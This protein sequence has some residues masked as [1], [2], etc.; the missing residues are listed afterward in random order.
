MY[1]AVIFDFDYT[2]GDTTDG[3][4]QSVNYALEELGYSSRDV[5]EIKRT[6]GMSL[7]ETFAALT[8]CEDAEKSESFVKLFR[9]KADEVMTDS[10]ELYDCVPEILRELHNT[11]RIGIVTTKFHYRIEAIL[12]KFSAAELVDVIVGAEDVKAEKP[13]PEGLLSAIS[14]LDVQKSEALYVGDSTVDAQTAQ[15]AE[16]DFAAV[17]TGTTTDFSQYHSVFVGESISD[18]F[19]FVTKR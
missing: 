11:R 12:R 9:E 5:S 8:D 7:R 3:I 15:N 2:L 14:R 1:N 6:I 10:A 13:A 19:N 16:V 17:R 4:V 18:I